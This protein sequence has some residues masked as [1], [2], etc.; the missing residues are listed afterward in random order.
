MAEDSL[1]KVGEHAPVGKERRCC[2]AVDS[3]R[4][5]PSTSLPS[6]PLPGGCWAPRLHEGSLPSW[7]VEG[8]RGRPGEVPGDPESSQA[9]GQ[10]Q[11]GEGSG[12][13]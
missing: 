3:T 10:S 2:L 4:R 5:A 1:G 9:P 6:E 11:S 13:F 12:V 7:R 8:L